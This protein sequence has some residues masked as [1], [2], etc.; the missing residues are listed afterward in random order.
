[1]VMVDESPGG[2]REH[3]PSEAA[4]TA[5]PVVLSREEVLAIFEA[6]PYINA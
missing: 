6:I 5:L 1:M 2:S 3:P 4:R